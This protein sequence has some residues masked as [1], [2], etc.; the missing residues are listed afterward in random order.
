MT[1]PATWKKADDYFISKLHS[2]DPDMSYILKANEEAGLPEIDVAPNQGKQLYLLAKMKGAKRI[3]EIGTLGGYSSIWLARALPEDG[4][5]I[6]LEYEEKHAKVAMENMKKAGLDHKIEI[7]VGAALYTLPALQDQ[8][9]FDFIFIDADKVN[10]PG[11]FEWAIK[12]SKPGT[13]IL[14]DNVVRGGKVIDENSGDEN[15]NGVRTLM[16][17]LSEE[18]GIEA[19]AIQTVGSKGY[20]GFV[21]GIV[22]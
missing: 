10:Y 16:D 9:P 7:I 4:Q 13:V 6:T 20:D 12:L 1:T 14:G 17:L 21:L 5:L 11:Y 8:E 15:V 18:P 2:A 22:K 3:L 19:T